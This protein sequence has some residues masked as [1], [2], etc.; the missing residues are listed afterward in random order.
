MGRL[1]VDDLKITLLPAI[2]LIVIKKKPGSKLFISTQESV[3]INREVL[4]QII[5]A[6]LFNNLLDTKVFEDILKET[7]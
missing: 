7:S 2:D 5:R 6:M 4:Y 3:M 1:D